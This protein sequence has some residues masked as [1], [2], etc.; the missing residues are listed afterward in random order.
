MFDPA[1]DIKRWRESELTHGRVA[2]LAALGF[3]VGEQLEDFP[4]FMN[5]DGS[6]TGPAIYQFQQVEEARPLFW[7]SLLL[8]IGLA[9]SFRVADEYEPGTLG[10]DP[11]GLKPSDPEELFELETKELNNGRLAMIGVAGFVLQELAVKR[12]IFEHLALYL[13]REAILEIEDLDPALNIALP[14]IP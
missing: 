1:N 11:L 5:F 7:E 2:M 8:F 10:F 4:A 13:E 12:G 14:T 3:V 9:E 6:I